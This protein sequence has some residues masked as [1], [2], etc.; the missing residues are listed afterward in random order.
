M[1]G[2]DLYSGMALTGAGTGAATGAMVGSIVPGVGTALG[3]GVGGLLGWLGG[4]ESNSMRSQAT[5][6]QSQNLD[7]IM[8]QLRQQ[9]S[10]NYDQHIADLNKAL[11]FYG[12]AQTYWDKLY[13]SGTGAQTTGQGSWSGTSPVTGGTAP[14]PTATTGAK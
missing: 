7:S 10:Q 12:P 3:A 11:S 6:Q 1:Q 9:S 13:G 5:Q 2:D 8:A 4:S 14:N